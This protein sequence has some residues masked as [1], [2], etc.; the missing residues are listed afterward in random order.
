MERRRSAPRRVPARERAPDVRARRRVPGPG[1]GRGEAAL[2][3]RDRGGSRLPARRHRGAGRA[4]ERDG[5]PDPG[6]GRGARRDRAAL[7]DRPAAG[8][9]ARA[10]AADGRPAARPLRRP[11]ARGGP[12]APERGAD[13]LDRRGRAGLR[14]HDEPRRPR[15][16]LQRGGGGDVRV[17]PRRRRRPAAGRADRAARA[18]RGASRGPGA[19]PRHRRG[20]DPQP[21]AR[22]R[23]DARGRQHV[24]R[25]ADGD[26]RRA[27]ASRRSSPA[28]CATSP[29]GGRRISS[30]AG[31]S[32]RRSR[33]GRARR[34][35]ACGPSPRRRARRWSASGWSSSPTSGC[36]WPRR[37]TTRRR[38]RRSR[39]RRSRTSPTCAPSRVSGLDGRPESLAVAHA[40]A[41]RERLARDLLVSASLPGAADAMRTGEYQLLPEITEEALV[42]AAARRGAAGA[43]A[44]ARA[45]LVAQ[46]P[47]AGVRPDPRR[48]H[49][50]LRGVRPPLRERGPGRRDRARR[51]RR[52]A[53][54]ERA[55]VHG[56]LAASRTRCRRACCR[57]S[58]RRS[59]G[60]RSPSRYDAAGDQNEVGGDFYDV[61]PSE[62]GVWTAIIGDVSGK[63]AE[64]RRADGP[65]PA[66]P[67]RRGAARGLA[68]AQ[69]RVPRPGDAQAGARRPPRSA[70]SSTCAC[71]RATARR[72]LTLASGGHPPALI[73]R[74]RRHDRARRDAGHARRRARATRGSRTATRGWRPAIC[75]CSTPTARSSCGAATSRSA[76]SS[77]SGCCASMRGCPAE[78]VVEAVG[79]PRRGAAGRL[80]A[81]RRRA[82]GP[83]SGAGAGCLTSAR[84]GWPRTRRASA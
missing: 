58:C 66:H 82:P 33:R 49:A 5:G 29:R 36:A 56:A 39:G 18:A 67:V 31:C 57:R 32:R 84:G 70:R 27:R 68:G 4:P 20:A 41:G 28:S 42:A 6:R 77:S 34:P 59:P 26:P 44:R 73:L 17:L 50:R 61:F 47:D 10:G 25:R 80:A 72:T 69:P 48:D 1:L 37:W 46:R 55:P 35:R 79:A 3:R 60:S 65:D 54:R 63:G 43:A 38:S 13:G 7:A 16:R 74:A 23:R 78:D 11:G 30:G 8:A 22:A 2:G 64:G 76:S 81:R 45:A 9:G 21:A 15:D 19:L 24:P 62:D 75:C 51:A 71:A 12:A 14:D 40:D 83:S 52:P 53:H